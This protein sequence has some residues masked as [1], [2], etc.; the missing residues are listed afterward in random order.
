M[1]KVLLLNVHRMIYDLVDMDPDPQGLL[2]LASFLEIKGYDSLVYHGEPSEARKFISH[3]SKEDPILAVGFYCDFENQT[4]V[5]ALSKEI[6]KQYQ[7]PV[8][9]G[10]PQ[11]KGFNAEYLLESQCLLGISGEGEIPLWQVLD[12]LYRNG[13]DWRE[14]QGI[15]FID[16]SGHFVN[17]SDGLLIEDADEL[18]MP[19]YHRW[20]NKPSRVR[21]S[22]MTGRGCPFRCAFCHEG[23]TTRTVRLRSVDNVLHELERLLDNEPDIRYVVFVDDTFTIT[24]KR[25]KQFCEAIKK[26]RE[27]RDFVWFCE[28]HVKLLH[29]WPEM[30]DDMASAGMIRLQTGIES[31]V[32]RVLDAYG[33][34]TTIQT[35]EEVVKYAYQAGL[36]QL[37]GFFIT[38]GPFEDQEI[39]Q[40]NKAFCE[41]LLELAPGMIELGPS[42]LMPYPGTV[43]ASCPQKYGISLVDAQGTTTFSDYP[44][45]ATA[46]LTREQIAAAQ[47]ELIRHGIVTMRRLF[48]EGK[49]P[50]ERILNIFNDLSYHATSTWHTAVFKVVPFVQ[51]Y[52]TLMAQ[53]AVRRSADIAPT[54][55]DGWR[56]QRILELWHDVDFSAG[57]PM[58][59]KE[60]LSPLEFQLLLYSTGK[61]RLHQVIDQVY[62]EFAARFS[63]RNDFRQTALSLFKKFEER[64]WLAYAPL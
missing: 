10:G 26:M 40:E 60:V 32:Q 18:P 19:A 53:G 56:P 4:E 30:M 22:I 6:S 61:L 63:D 23:A 11:V 7:V 45:T 43:I 24:P 55:L 13:G 12:C 59:G 47:Q 31:G 14:V 2:A 15:V 57:F 42:P 25:V 27:K 39:V 38:G 21:A 52:Y 51:G 50:H 41:R 5:A 62:Q 8:I 46:A 28:G 33:K 17:N 9:L 36:H 44:V 29:R 64:Y 3:Q 37:A 1:G 35:I 16:D 34:Q 20:V 54:D 48:K 58:I 49:V